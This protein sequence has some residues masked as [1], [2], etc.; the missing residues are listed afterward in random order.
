MV[1][2]P[3]DRASVRAFR[4]ELLSFSNFL[5]ESADEQHASAFRDYAD[6]LTTATATKQV[7]DVQR[8]VKDAFRYSKADFYDQPASNPD[9]PKYRPTGTGSEMLTAHQEH[10]ERL[11]RYARRL[12][13]F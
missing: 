7:R 8:K 9:S 13:W 6:S 1:P 11:L 3:T 4:D 2:R 12:F 5:A 10:R